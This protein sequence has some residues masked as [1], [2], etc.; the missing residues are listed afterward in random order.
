MRVK[1][2][3]AAL[4]AVACLLTAASALAGAA[5]D[6]A[7][8]DVF[9]PGYDAAIVDLTKRFSKSPAEAQDAARKLGGMGKR[10]V[11]PLNDVL[12][13]N[14]AQKEPSP[15]ITYYTIW[16]L[17]R[18]K[19]AQ[20][21]QALLPIL[22][23]E[24]QAA[25][26]RLIAVD[27]V[28]MEL[29]PEG[30]ALLLKIAEK[31]ADAELRMRAFTQLSLM[32]E[33][34]AKAEK[35]FIDA[36]SSPNDAIRG[37]AAKQCYFSRIYLNAADKLIELAE[38]DSAQTIR[39]NAILALERMRIKRAVPALVRAACAADAT[40]PMQKLCVKAIATLSGYAFK[41][42]DALKKWWE[43]SEEEY[44]KLLPPK[45]AAP[46]AI[47][48]APP[49]AEPPP[50]ASPSVPPAP[51]PIQSAPPVAPVK[52]LPEPAAT[53][54][55]KTPA[56]DPPPA[57]ES[58]GARRRREMREAEEAVRSNGNPRESAPRP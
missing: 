22:K 38:K 3:P 30:V 18:I 7:T 37:I 51:E 8:R 6:D 4:L 1:I 27:A 9:D 35:I 26:L 16:S 32:P 2:V 24:K 21:A 54:P 29:L 19:S 33:T 53:A 12:R 28:G 42:L 43:K 48:E 10:A 58:T 15:Q 17:A 23:D 14:L 50:S 34:W 40:P 45:P 57:D 5:P 44:A 55:R 31:D 13:E 41:D 36:L 20:A 52:E 46:A 39:V 25:E 47:P 56:S 11:G 49:A